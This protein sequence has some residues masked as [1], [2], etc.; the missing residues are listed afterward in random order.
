[1]YGYSKEH[2]RAEMGYDLMSEHWGDG[3]MTEAVEAMVS[4]GFNKLGLERI[5]ATVDPENG[6]SIRTLEKN[7]FKQEGLLRQR[8]RKWGQYEDVVLSAILQQEW[9]NAPDS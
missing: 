4:Y 8:V 9:R 7:G 5:E 1:M 6:A 3:Y 2:R